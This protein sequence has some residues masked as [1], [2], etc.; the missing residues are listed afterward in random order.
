LAQRPHRLRR[1]RRPESTPKISNNSECSH[2]CAH[3]QW[4]LSTQGTCRKKKKTKKKTKIHPRDGVGRR[5]RRPVFPAPGSPSPFP[6]RTG[7]HPDRTPLSLT[8][9]RPARAPSRIRNRV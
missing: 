2:D 5:R 9:P 3:S 8:T 4:L 6:Q 1:R 7:R